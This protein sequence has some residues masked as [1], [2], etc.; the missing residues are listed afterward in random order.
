MTGDP[1]V[2]ATAQQT[3]GLVAP[4][5]IVGVLP[6][7]PGVP[8]GATAVLYTEKL[9]NYFIAGRTSNTANGT[10]SST[11]GGS[12]PF[13]ASETAPA[14]LPTPSVS[15]PVTV[16]VADDTKKV[17]INATCTGLTV[18]T[19]SVNSGASPLIDTLT[20]CTVP[21]AD[22]GDTFTSND[23]VSLPGG[24]YESTATLAKTGEGS[25]NQ[26][27]T[28]KNNEDLTVLRVA[29]TTDGVNFSS[30]GLDNNGVISGQSAG[31]TPYTDISNPTASADPP[32]GLNQ[33][34]TPGTTDSHGDALRG[35][36]RLRRRQP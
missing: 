9:L 24:A 22:N 31:S 7:Y 4:D 8:S 35:L 21:T 30:A 17:D 15:S 13:Y 36:G 33:Y 19:G 34:A 26:D 29:Y 6:T 18:G 3:N 14:A 25:T 23:N 27:K 12:I 11:T 20:G 28:F 32:G 16:V 10:Y 5:G 2:P 1:I